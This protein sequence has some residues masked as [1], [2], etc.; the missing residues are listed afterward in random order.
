MGL[1]AI[2]NFTTREGFFISKVYVRIVFT[3]YNLISG[4][5]V[6]QFGCY[7]D[8]DARLAGR[9]PIPIPYMTDVHM[10]H[11]G[12]LPSIDVLYF[13]LK[14]QLRSLGLTVD[15]VLED[16]QTSST[17]SQPDRIE[18]PPNPDAVSNT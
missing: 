2:T 5:T 10:F 7:L 3:S 6:V 16:G 1:L 18:T 9:Q 17:Y 14:K 13:H 12:S 15:D 4:V 8:R 11:Y